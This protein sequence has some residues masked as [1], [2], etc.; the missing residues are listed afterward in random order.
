[1]SLAKLNI[2]NRK[3]SINKKICKKT[4]SA[5]N[6]PQDRGQDVFGKLQEGNGN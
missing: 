4:Y 3:T 6:A 2:R 1:M 5:W